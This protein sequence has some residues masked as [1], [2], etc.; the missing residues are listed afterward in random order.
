MD[1]QINKGVVGGACRTRRRKIYLYWVGV[2][3]LEEKKILE[4]RVE[5]ERIILK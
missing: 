4:D 1:D 2:W 5:N 3:K